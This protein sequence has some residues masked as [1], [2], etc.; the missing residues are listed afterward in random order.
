MLINRL[1]NAVLLAL[2]L[3]WPA[4]AAA[5]DPA[6]CR[7]SAQE[8][9]RKVGGNVVQVFS[10]GIDPH[11]VANRVQFGTGSGVLLKP[12]L[13]LTNYH[14][15]EGATLMGVTS[16]GSANE[17]T[18]LGG[19]PAFD[20]A[21]LSV[22]AQMGPE[23]PP[24]FGS[25]D[26]LEVGAPAYV[27]G[28]PLGVGKSLTSGIISGLD[29]Q[30]PLNTISWTTRYI[31]TDASVSGGNSGGPLLDGCGRIVG[32]VTL[33]SSGPETE[34]MAYA[35]PIDAI[36]PLLDEITETGK[37]ARPWH[38]LYGQMMTPLIGHL[39]ML[40][41]GYLPQGFLVET[42]ESGSA[43]DRAGIRGGAIPVIWGKSQIIL[44]GDVITEVNGQPIRTL[45]QALAAVR[46]I[47]IGDT[48]QLK[49][50]RG[51]ALFDLSAEIGE[52]PVMTSDL[53]FVRNR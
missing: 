7:I 8:I 23:A 31:Q 51:G 13:V 3:G 28:Y 19:D 20:I 39:M 12:G 53:D 43:A 4:M 24:V 41:P 15:V 37:V 29:R 16:N 30:I 2:L 36:L 42:V 26:A 46:S 10:L 40:P 45:E 27:L 14:V 22:P 34:N 47:R 33:R 25:Y 48:V 18:L 6:D 38:G 21:L 32:L 44:G 9:F 35:L 49:V 11:R 52:R 50:W 17:A 5:L 1:R